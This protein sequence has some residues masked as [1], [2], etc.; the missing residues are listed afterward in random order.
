MPICV[1]ACDCGSSEQLARQALHRYEYK[2]WAMEPIYQGKAHSL[3][4]VE[5]L[6]RKFPQNPQLESLF[7]FIKGSGKWVVILGHDDQEV[8]WADISR[9]RMKEDADAEAIVRDFS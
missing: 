4:S 3:Q 1:L 8:R 2:N 7:N 5:N 6:L 9:N